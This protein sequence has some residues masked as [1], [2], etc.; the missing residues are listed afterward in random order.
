M[1]SL[2]RRHPRTHA[3]VVALAPECREPTQSNWIACDVAAAI[4]DGDAPHAT[5]IFLD[6]WDRTAFG[7]SIT[8]HRYSGNSLDPLGDADIRRAESRAIAAFGR[9]TL[10]AYR[11]VCASDDDYARAIAGAVDAIDLKSKKSLAAL[12]KAHFA[13]LGTPASDSEDDDR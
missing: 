1:A 6:A 7:Q 11:K 4:L 12:R 2:E 9:V 5:P 10:P 8:D 13:A 3:A